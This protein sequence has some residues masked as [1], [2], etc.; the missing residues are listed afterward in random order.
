MYL[1]FLIMQLHHDYQEKTSYKLFIAEILPRPLVYCHIPLDT[2][3]PYCPQSI[4]LPCAAN[5]NERLSFFLL[6]C[7]NQKSFQVFVSYSLIFEHMIVECVLC[8]IKYIALDEKEWFN[9][10]S[11]IVWGSFTGNA[12]VH[13]RPKHINVPQ[14]CFQQYQSPPVV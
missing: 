2:N 10:C 11:R 9:E 12:A 4:S 7:V 6:F 5:S 13:I 1:Q 3:P 8:F 14:V